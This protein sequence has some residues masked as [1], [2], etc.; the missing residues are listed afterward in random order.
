MKLQR[1]QDAN[2]IINLKTKVKEEEE[3]NDQKKKINQIQYGNWIEF[4]HLIV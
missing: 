3:E 4:C 1:E 2:W